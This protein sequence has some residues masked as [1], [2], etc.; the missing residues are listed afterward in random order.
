MW[1]ILR[2]KEVNCHVKH[3]ADKYCTRHELCARNAFDRG[4]MEVY[5]RAVEPG[6]PWSG[7]QHGTGCLVLGAAKAVTTRAALDP[8]AKAMGPPIEGYCR[9]GKLK[10]FSSPVIEWIFCYQVCCE[11][12]NSEALWHYKRGLCKQVLGTQRICFGPWF[13]KAGV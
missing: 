4:K 2:S 6:F 10:Y 5:G 11:V 7:M 13:S 12:N 1:S 9:K 3:K 8:L